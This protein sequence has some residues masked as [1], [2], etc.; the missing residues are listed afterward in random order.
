MKN[1]ISCPSIPLPVSH[2]L[3]TSAER[4]GLISTEVLYFRRSFSKNCI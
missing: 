3:N 1:Q 2:S 4:I